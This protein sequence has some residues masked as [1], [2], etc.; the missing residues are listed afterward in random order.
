MVYGNHIYYNN[1]QLAKDKIHGKRSGAFQN[2]NGMHGEVYDNRIH[3][4]VVW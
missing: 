2:T 4:I 1:I 3:R